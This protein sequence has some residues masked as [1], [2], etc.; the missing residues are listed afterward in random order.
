MKVVVMIASG[1]ESKGK[2]LDIGLSHN[3]H[4]VTHTVTLTGEA[5]NESF[6]FEVGAGDKLKIIGQPGKF[7]MKDGTF[8]PE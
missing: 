6:Y 4:V 2:V 7:V 1:P 8:V 5:D 3:G